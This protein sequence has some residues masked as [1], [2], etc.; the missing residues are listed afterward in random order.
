MLLD[1]QIRS[2]AKAVLSEQ[3]FAAVKASVNAYIKALD[4]GCLQAVVIEAVAGSGKTHTLK[5]LIRVL[6]ALNPEI[7]ICYLVFNGRNR[8]EMSSEIS[9]S[10]ACVST[11]H[12]K[13][14]NSF[15]DA[16]NVRIDTDS[17]KTRDICQGK[18]DVPYYL[19]GAVCEL[20]K[21]V[22]NRALKTATKA[23][24]LDIIE[25]F[26]IEEKLLESG[27]DK[28]LDEL[29]DLTCHYAAKVAAVSFEAC[30]KGFLD[31]EDQLLIPVIDPCVLTSEDVKYDVVLIDECQDTSKVR[32][33]LAAKLGKKASL[34]VAVGDRFQAIYG[35]TGADNNAVELIVERFNAE[36]MPLSITYR[37]P[38]SHVRFAK[39]L[40]PEAAI[41]AAD[42]AP[43]GLLVNISYAEMMKTITWDYRDII[44]CRYN[45][46]LLEITFSLLAKGI[47]CQI[48]GKNV[49]K[50]LVT[51]SK[52]WKTV[53]TLAALSDKLQ[54]WG[55][56]QQEKLIAQEHES[57]ADNLKDQIACLQFFIDEM[58][59]NAS[60]DDLRAKIE[61][62][63]VNEDGE[64]KPVL[65]LMSCHKSK[66]LEADRVFWIGRSKFQPSK[67][68]RKPWQIQ[69][70]KHLIYVATTRSRNE[71]YDVTY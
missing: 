58:P 1:D 53:K 30:Y 43:E 27:T 54:S 42:A 38:K 64:L 63:F 51:L 3:Q 41:E 31:F 25:Y 56:A 26:G 7:R 9:A 46:P 37:C 61:S 20:V 21:Q 18:L 65:T 19:Q 16:V 32:R 70:E 15:K 14:F 24:M 52:K 40:L 13:G 39:E 23:E 8:I 62:M 34:I 59:A 71:L 49:A 66:G 35:F 48:L 28:E 60:L 36:V 11:F 57:A 10:E 5:A 55:L 50:G 22:K 67:L 29:I 69:Q 47:P 33:E 4:L 12:S 45:K 17:N 44:L 68:A 2:A 6:K